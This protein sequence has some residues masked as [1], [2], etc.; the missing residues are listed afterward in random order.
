MRKKMTAE[1]KDA[2]ISAMRRER[3]SLQELEEYERRKRPTFALNMYVASFT[4][5]SRQEKKEIYD[6]L[7]KAWAWGTN[8]KGRVI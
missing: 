7:R 8:G 6:A 2:F 4:F 3:L 1:D 5:T